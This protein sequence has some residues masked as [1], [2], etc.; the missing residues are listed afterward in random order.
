[1]KAETDPWKVW[2]SRADA[3]RLIPRL[4]ILVYYVFSI[5]A[6]WF[7]VEWFMAYD[8]AALESE[9]VALAVVGFPAVILGV[10]TTVLGSLTNNYFRTGGSQPPT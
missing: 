3:W 9:I 4:L 5:K 2:A 1:M 6:W 10:I 7:V 8:F